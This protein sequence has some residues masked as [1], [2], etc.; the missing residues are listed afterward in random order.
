MANNADLKK[1]LEK[2]SAGA[3]SASAPDGYEDCIVSFI[4]VLG[5]RELLKKPAA[6]VIRILTI[7]RKFASADDRRPNTRQ[8]KEL[9]ATSRAFSESVS[10]AVV[11]IRVYD[12]QYR[13]GAFFHEL[14]DLLHAQV[15]CVNNDVLVR[16]GVAIGRAHVG[17]NGEGPIFGDAM[18]RAYRIESEEAIYPRIV[19]DDDAYQ[20]FLNDERLRSEDND[21]DEERAHVDRLLCIGEDGTRYI[22]YLRA[23]LGECDCEI[24]YYDFLRRH[25]DLIRSGLNT[26]KGRVRRKYVWL[27]RYH[28]QVVGELLTGFRRG[29]A[30]AEFERSWE[31]DPVEFL[32]G[33]RIAG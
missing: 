8:A 6:D 21:L 1:T 27:S 14:I 19:V 9:R 7:L 28:D 2:K 4:D 22:D 15:D 11:R 17:A 18:A 24:D 30:A 26:T 23:A 33:I 3:A 12:T 25:A 16:A 13:D 29:D 20:A 32:E 31:V 5:F 10:D